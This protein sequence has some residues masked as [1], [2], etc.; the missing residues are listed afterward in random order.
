MVSYIRSRRADDAG[1]GCAQIVGNGTQEICPDPFFFS[2][3]EFAFSLRDHLILFGELGGHG[4]GCDGN[5]QHTYESDRISAHGKVDLK[6]RIS[7][8][9]V[10]KNDAE[11]GR[12]DA[13]QVSG[14]SPRNQDERQDIDQ[15]DIGGIILH[16]MKE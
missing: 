6:K 15:C 7:K 2:F 9:S 13:V 10:D 4:A 16:K 5:D 14:G 8:T 12:E 11:Q 3:I 1:Q